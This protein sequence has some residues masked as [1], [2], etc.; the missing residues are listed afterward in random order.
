MD[1]GGG[2]GQFDYSPQILSHCIITLCSGSNLQPEDAQHLILDSLICCHHP[3]IFNHLP[4]LWLKI[5]KHL[6]Q[7][8]GPFVAHHADRLRQMLVENET[9]LSMPTLERCLRTCINLNAEAILP[10][11]IDRALRELNNPAI[12]HVTK[13]EYFTYLTPKGQL[14]DKSVIATKDSENELNARNMKRESKVY[15]YKE[16]L[17]ELQLRR[18]LEEKRRKAGKFKEPELTP[19]Q[20]EALRQ[21]LA[22]ESAIRQRLDGLNNQIS[23]I[24]SM[25]QAAADGNGDALAIHFQVKIKRAIL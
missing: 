18:E 9:S 20:K 2:I 1:S 12:A 25:L 6:R 16:Q 11:I 13:N 22:K 19:K 8:P 7:E 23:A 4:N 17:E 5:S 21:Q 14:Y 24:V 3:I 15:S 10:A